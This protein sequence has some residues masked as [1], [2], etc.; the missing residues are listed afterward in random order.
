[1][2]SVSDILTYNYC[3]R[4]LFLQKVL[5]IV[6]KAPREITFSGTIKHAV[7]EYATNQEQVMICSIL[8]DSADVF[9]LYKQLFAKGLRFVLL[10]EKKI[11]EQ[12]Q[13]NMID[14]YKE[15]ILLFD[16]AITEKTAVVLRAIKEFHVYGNDLWEKLPKIQ[17][18]CSVSSSSL[19]LRGVIDQL[20]LFGEQVVPLELKTGKAPKQGVY[21]QHQLQIAAYILLLQEKY[22]TVTYGYVYYL[23]NNEKRKVLINPFMKQEVLQLI[24]LSQKLLSKQVLPLYCENKQKCQNCE[25]KKHCYDESYIVEKMQNM[26]KHSK[27][28]NNT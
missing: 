26:Q 17:A 9:V 13:K 22:P 24:D 10:R 28:L 8:D 2:L 25:I 3:Q 7:F 20:E 19:G 12:L 18:E 6:E 1:M 4:K 21:E 16:D 11:L 14:V 23:A 27:A 5:G 15:Y